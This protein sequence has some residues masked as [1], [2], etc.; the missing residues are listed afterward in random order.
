MHFLEPQFQNFL[1][2]APEPPIKVGP[3]PPR[4]PDKTTACLFVSMVH[5]LLKVI[6]LLLPVFGRTLQENILVLHRC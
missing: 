1:G 2:E 3:P 6:L 4:G 5:C